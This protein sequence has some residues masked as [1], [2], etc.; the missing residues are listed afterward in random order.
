[1]IMEKSWWHCIHNLEAER[2]YVNAQL[3]LS[4]NLSST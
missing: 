4:L 1:M 2:D 3:P